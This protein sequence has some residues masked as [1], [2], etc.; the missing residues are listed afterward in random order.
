VSKDWYTKLKPIV[1]HLNI[2]G[3]PAVQATKVELAQA[4]RSVHNENA[5]LQEEIKKLK[6]EKD[7]ER[8]TYLELM[9]DFNTKQQQNGNS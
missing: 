9:K 1:G 5:K 4:L 8:S 3:K 2:A 7:Q 6:E